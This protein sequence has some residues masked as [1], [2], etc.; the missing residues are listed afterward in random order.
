[1]GSRAVPAI[2]A[3][4]L[5]ASCQGDAAPAAE[6]TPPAP[7]RKPDVGAAPVA[8]A[9]TP[10]TPAAPAPPPA[11]PLLRDVPTALRGRVALRKVLSG[12]RRPVLVAAA[13]GDRERLFAVEQP[14]RIRIARDGQLAPRPFLDL[15]GKVSTGNEQG[16]LGLA[17]HPGFAQNG[18]LYVNYTDLDDDTH[19]VEYRVS[20]TDPDRIDPSSRREVFFLRQPYANHNG[21]DLVFGPDG[22]LWIGLGDGGSAGDPHGAGQDPGN[23]LA[24]MLRL[25]VDAARPA[26]EIVALGLR[27]PWRYAFDP[28]TGDLYIG[29]VGQNR[30]ESIYVVAGDDLT[31]HN[32]GWN[33]VEGA[34]CFERKRC[35]RSRFTAPVVDYPH[36]EG[37]SVTGGVVYRGAAV[38]ELA[39]VY[40]YADYCT[41]LLRSLRWIRASGVRD[42]WNWKPVL[43]PGNRVSS[44]S[45]FGVDA[46]GELYIVTLVGD[47]Y[48]LVPAGAAPP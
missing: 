48:Q 33:V 32:F 29:D 3:A 37:C 28:A 18:R 25:D 47:V 21:G 22:K 43:D 30:W 15:T 31:G 13:P 10:P 16:L 4:I 44:I 23:L 12:L 1:M 11:D 24:K 26:P 34:H 36:T 45:S 41:G 39:G 35:D 20:A 40:F 42:H 27:N 2:F 46:A 6:R 38:P 19:V 17:F 8:P 5:A 14:G 9:T 7:V